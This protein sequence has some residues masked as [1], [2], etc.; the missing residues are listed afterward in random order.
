M[1]FRT[2]HFP[3]PKFNAQGLNL[4][5]ALVICSVVLNWIYLVRSGV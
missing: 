3:D 4:F 1:Y 5:R 2:G